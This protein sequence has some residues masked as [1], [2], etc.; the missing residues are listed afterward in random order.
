MFFSIAVHSETV[1][2]HKQ[3]ETRY[4]IAL[5]GDKVEL[6]CFTDTSSPLEWYFKNGSNEREFINGSSQADSNVTDAYR[7]V[8]ETFGQETLVI[9]HVLLKHAGKYECNDGDKKYKLSVELTVV[10]EDIF[11]T[12]K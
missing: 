7:I 6:D 2:E 3:K 4:R 9:D 12:N 10:G 1:D 11:R 8:S 5:L